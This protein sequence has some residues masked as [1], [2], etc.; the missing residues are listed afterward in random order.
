MRR[1][2]MIMFLLIVFL[3]VGYGAAA[4][5]TSPG[6]AARA[7]EGGA[8]AAAVDDANP[9]SRMTDIHDIKP[10]EKDTALPAW[11]LYGAAA[12]GAAGLLAGL[13]YYARRRRRRRLDSIVAT[14]LPEEVANRLL[15]K[16]SSVEGLAAKDFYFRLSAILRGYIKDRFGLH[17]TEMTTEEFLPR[18][19]ELRIDPAL[20]KGV[21][22]LAVAT[23]PI[24]FAGARGSESRM[25]EDL[26]FVK[27]F[28][29][30]TT[31]SLQTP[32]EAADGSADGRTPAP[33]ETGDD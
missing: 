27:T 3:S 1:S 4:E 19:D 8:P 9:A 13:V 17:A 2:A 28:V 14:V 18:L 12:L 33:I 6:G 11:L 21:K 24:K 25:A 22:K 30:S 16:L 23:D 31:P 7:A 29:R 26:C 10:P 15:G 32:S 20:Q 5:N